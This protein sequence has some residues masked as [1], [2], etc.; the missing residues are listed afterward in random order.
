MNKD[1]SEDDGGLPGL[2]DRLSGL[3]AVEAHLGRQ[4]ERALGKLDLALA[5]LDVI[6][7]EN[8]LLMRQILLPQEQNWQGQPVPVIDAA[9]AE[10]AFARSSLCQAE[11]F[12]QPYFSY[13]TGALG[14]ILR[15]HRKLWEFVFICQV[16][17]ERGMIADGRRALG[18]GVGAEPLTAYFAAHGVEIVATD[19]APED[20]MAAGWTQTAQH[21]AGKES[22][23]RPAICPDEA[24]DRNV[25]FRNVDMNEVPDDLTGF[26]FCWSACALEHL[27]SIDHGLDFIERSLATLK[28]GGLAVH[29]TEFNLGS[30]WETLETGSTVLFRRRDLEGLMERLQARGHIVTPI[31][32]HPGFGEVD[33]YVDVA[34]YLEQPHLK[35]AL[36]GF[37]TTSIGLIVQRGPD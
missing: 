20:A 6:E 4:L 34:P 12:R 11:H 36:E 32:F 16:L 37:A 13:W 26:D 23:R 17:Y 24:F 10:L 29:T 33:R 7:R 30:D 14:E 9:P 28:P 5:R 8:R 1:Q 3:A 35:M 25:S 27:G 15:Y 2:R 21:A 22:L 19:M 18:F 31:D